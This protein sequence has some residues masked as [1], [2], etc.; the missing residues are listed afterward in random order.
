MEEYGIAERIVVPSSF[1]ASSFLK[2]GVPQ[3]RLLTVPLGVDLGTFQPASPRQGR[4]PFRLLFVGAGTVEK[5]LGY[6]LQAWGRLRLPGAELWMVC[7]VSRPPG[8][9]GSLNRVRWWR[10][11]DHA[12]LKTI[13]QEASVFCL[14]SVQDGFGMVVLEAMACGLP[15]IIS[16]HVGAKDCVRDGI[17]GFIVPIRNVP[18]LAEKVETLY[19]NPD[20]AAEMG[21][22][23]FRRARDF[24]WDAYGDRMLAGYQHYWGQGSDAKVV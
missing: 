3:N 22:Q 11:F 16:D 6:L 18:A 14:P 12:K 2:A 15:V 8:Y 5:G 19:R 9:S 24:S 17:D 4:R 20:L 13:Y 23:A 10:H 7:P 1:V 21:R